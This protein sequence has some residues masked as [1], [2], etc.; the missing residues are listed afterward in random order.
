[1]AGKNYEIG[2]FTLSA[3]SIFMVD[4]SLQTAQQNP[5]MQTGPNAVLVRRQRSRIR[6]LNAI[7]ALRDK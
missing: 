4:F 2:A 5:A 1:V 7:G 6:L 3:L